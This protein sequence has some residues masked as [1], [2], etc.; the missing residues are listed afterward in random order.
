MW[1]EHRQ[2]ERSDRRNLRISQ[3]ELAAQMQSIRDKSSRDMMVRQLM[4][5]KSEG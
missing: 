1:A 4:A 2:R 3:S 5:Q